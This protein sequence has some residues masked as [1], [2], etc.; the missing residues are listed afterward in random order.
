[1]AGLICATSKPFDAY[2]IGYCIEY[3]HGI[4]REDR[5]DVPLHDRPGACAEM[6]TIYGYREGEGVEAICDRY[7]QQSAL[8]TLSAILGRTLLM[9][10]GATW[11]Q[12]WVKPHSTTEH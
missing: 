8:D 7:D 12:W 10:E 4:E 9:P 6:W 2:E 11:H 3:E 1:M 5:C